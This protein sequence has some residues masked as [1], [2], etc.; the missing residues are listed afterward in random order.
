MNDFNGVAPPLQTALSD[1]GYS[2]LTPVQTAMIDPAH[3]G[4]DLLVSAQTGS[5]KTVAFGIAMASTLLAGAERF[6]RA[7]A[8]R[9]LVV[10][11]T[12]E[13]ALQVAREL[14]WLFDATGAR[15]A[16]CVGGMDIS[17]ERRA[18]AR[19]AHIVVGTPGRLVDHVRRGA[20]AL[21][22]IEAIV[23][24][25][26]DEMLDLGFREELEHLLGAA[27]DDRQTLLFSA[28]VSPPIAKLAGRYQRDAVRVTTLSDRKQ[29]SDIEYRAL[30]VATPDHENAIFNLLRFNADQKALVFCGTRAAVAHMSARLTN[31][32]IPTVALSGELSQKERTHALQAVRDGR[33]RVCVATDVAARGIDLPDLELVIHSDIPR[34]TEA[35]LH[36]SG[37]TGRAG[38]KGASVLIVP[39][40]ARK[41]TERLLR[42]A[43]VK[44]IWGKPPS[45]AE[46]RESD[47]QRLIS[48]PRLSTPIE[49][50]ERAAVEALLSAHGPEQVAAAFLRISREGL[51]APEDLLDEEPPRARREKGEDNARAPRRS[52][53]NGAWIALSVGHDQ[54]ADVRWLLPMLC[55]AGGLTKADIGA[56]RIQQQETWVELAPDQADGFMERLGPQRRLEDTI[57]V[58]RLAER[59]TEPARSDDERTRGTH[60]RLGGG[61]R[62]DQKNENYRGGNRGPGGGRRPEGRASGPGRSGFDGK[63]GRGRPGPRGKPRSGD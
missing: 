22:E 41:R 33:A 26:A 51:A 23:L 61:G 57:R 27:P 28:T 52:F 2:E 10:A 49:D 54:R 15:I 12:R 5:G 35:L 9:G 39:G 63:S 34:N 17:G 29:H 20:L 4:V 6:E 56:I 3:Q 45:A 32:G 50:E 16:T 46:I 48:D 31:R 43:N 21:D 62:D 36:R 13:L 37:R 14:S 40:R 55:N 19:G 30:T 38:R 8:P 44:A 25:E 60:R 1:R 47:D 11:P 53:D 58:A 42:E 59:P 18:L 7:S 24:D